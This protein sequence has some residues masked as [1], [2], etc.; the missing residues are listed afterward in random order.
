M[1]VV[2]KKTD[3]SFCLTSEDIRDNCFSC[4]AEKPAD[5]SILVVIKNKK[6]SRSGAQKRLKFLWMCFLA[7]EKAGEGDGLDTAGWNA[8]FK[9]KFIKAILIAQDDKYVE[10]F[11][12]IRRKAIALKAGLS[13]EEYMDA[14]VELWNEVETLW[15]TV[16]SMAKFMEQIDKYCSYKLGVALP[17]PSNLGWLCEGGRW[18]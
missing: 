3:I 17:L 13:H 15:L 4:I 2:K 6:E 18:T 7:K 5:G 1:E 12:K 16:K 10:T 8:F 9:E 11:A 14:K